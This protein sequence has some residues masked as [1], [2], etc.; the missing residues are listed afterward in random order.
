ME[1]DQAAF[2][3]AALGQ[4]TRLD[5]LRIL[6]D[7][8]P[9]GLAAGEV[10]GRLGVP[11]STLSF[12]LRALDQAGLIAAT[13]QGRSLIYAV[14]FA[15]LRALLAFLAEACCGGEPERCGDLGRMLDTFTRENTTMQQPAFSV[16]FLCTHN[17][18]RSIM[19][20]AIMTKLAPG[21]FAAFSAGSDPSPAGP[22][23]EVMSLL[24]TLGHDVSGLRSKS[25]NEYT[26]PAAPKMDFVLTL[27][28]TLHGQICPDFGTTVI[29]GAWPLPDPAKFSG[30]LAERGTL[31]NEVY[32]GLRR[33]LEA[34][35]SLP[36]ASLDRMALKARVD[37]L[38]DPHAVLR[39]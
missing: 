34:F 19:A 23:P 11:P 30:S 16:L 26:G 24:K 3:F 31:L 12:H 15:R 10:A 22:L 29:T 37:E 28:D 18:A 4:G 14:Q 2:A 38:A 36:F 1:T 7:A 9:S 20:E 27:C 35:T 6:L 5:L 25:W 21:R 39:A 32:A 33:R 8:G 13:R 17:S